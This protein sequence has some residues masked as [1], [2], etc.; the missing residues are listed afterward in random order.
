MLYNLIQTRRGKQSIV[1][2]DSRPRVQNRVKTL[3]KSLRKGIKGDKV[4]FHIEPTEDTVKF[5]KAP[6]NPR[7][8]GCD[9]TF[10]RKVKWDRT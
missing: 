3:R 4:S 8:G 5:Q 7:I 10:P 1:M 9:V 6:H 2:T